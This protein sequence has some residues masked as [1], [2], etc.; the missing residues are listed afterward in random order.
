MQNIKRIKSIQTLRLAFTKSYSIHWKPSRFNSTE[1][2]TVTEKGYSTKTKVALFTS[3]VAATGFTGFCYQLKTNEEFL[4][5]T[6]N[7]SPKLVSS[8]SSI[9]NLPVSY[10]EDAEPELVT[11]VSLEELVGEKIFAKCL[12]KSGKVVQYEINPNTS[13]DEL[14]ELHLE[15]IKDD[16]IVNFEFNS[17]GE[18]V[19]SFEVSVPDVSHLLDNPEATKQELEEMRINLTQIYQDLLIQEQLNQ[20]YMYD[21]SVTEKAI[22]NCE[23]KIQALDEKIKTKSGWFS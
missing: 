9:L 14:R 6:F 15:K 8:L 5:S 10:T 16:P 2:Q 7:K 1:V 20:K 22:R 13:L 4:L 18:E 23:T 3:A 19:S 11:P 21:N 12:L 17:T